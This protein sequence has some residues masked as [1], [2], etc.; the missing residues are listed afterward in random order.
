MWRIS[1]YAPQNTD[2]KSLEVGPVK[3]SVAHWSICA[4]KLGISVVHARL[5]RHKIVMILWRIEVRCATE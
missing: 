2:L 5:M 4:T 3:F 1:A